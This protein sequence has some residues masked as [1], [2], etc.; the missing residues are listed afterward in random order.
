MPFGCEIR[1]SLLVDCL[2][3][4]TASTRTNKQ[5]KK[6]TVINYTGMESNWGCKVTSKHLL[7]QLSADNPE[8]I[9]RINLEV[10]HTLYRR[11][12][13]KLR[14]LLGPLLINTHLITKLLYVFELLH[15]IEREN[16]DK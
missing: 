1:Q 8:T 7:L 14:T 10:P 3:A 12:I 16:L 4:T 2:A 11:C 5:M 13:G 6:I 9:E 15:S